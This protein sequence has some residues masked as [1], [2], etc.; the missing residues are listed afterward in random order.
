MAALVTSCAVTWYHD[1][2]KS[3]H[4]VAQ[5]QGFLDNAKLFRRA[6][7]RTLLHYL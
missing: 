5:A 4:F 7:E 3:C 1:Q 2:Q 6:L